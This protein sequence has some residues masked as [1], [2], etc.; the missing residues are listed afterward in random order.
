LFLLIL[1]YRE[2]PP[3]IGGFLPPSQLKQVFISVKVEHRSPLI[4]LAAVDIYP[5]TQVSLG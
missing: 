1:H 2:V 4:D 3:S 5:L